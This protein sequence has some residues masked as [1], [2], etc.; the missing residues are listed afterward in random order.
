MTP[1]QLKEIFSSDRQSVLS[2]LLKPV[3]KAPFVKDILYVL[4]VGGV[5]SI[6]VLMPGF[7]MALSSIVKARE[8]YEFN[9]R[10]QGMKK[11]G[12]ITISKNDKGETIVEIASN[13]VKRAMKYKFED[14]VLKKQKVWD[15]KWRVVIFDVAESK[16]GL[17]DRFRSK[18]AHLGFYGLN[19]SV[20]IYPYSCFDEVEFIRQY[21]FVGAEVTYLQVE[22]IEDD[23]KLRRLFDLS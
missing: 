9:R 2:K 7:G 13:G 23:T 11:R 18:L 14:M 3:D 1:E 6:A 5:V 4:A 22:K 15:G 8:K 20:L 17:R 21:Y 16:R 10:I 19:E 12:Y